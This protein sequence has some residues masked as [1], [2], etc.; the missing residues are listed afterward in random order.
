MLLYYGSSRSFAFFCPCRTPLVLAL[1]IRSS[2]SSCL[3]QEQHQQRDRSSI[4]KEISEIYVD[5][6][7]D[8]WQSLLSQQPYISP[9]LWKSNTEWKDFID[10]L[11]STHPDGDELWE[12]VK[13]EAL[14]SLQESAE[15]GPL[16]YQC[17]LSQKTLLEA[18]VTVIS[19]KFLLMERSSVGSC[20]CCAKTR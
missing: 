9:M 11:Y 8:L 17:I 16:L 18:V 20:Y 5:D 14:Q 6:D 2:T 7:N 1:S 12:Q 19:R 10:D 15:A 4:L 3:Q 13:L